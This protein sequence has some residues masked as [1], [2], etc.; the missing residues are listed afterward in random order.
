MASKKIH[1]VSL[2]CAKNQ[3]DSEMML[4][5]LRMAGW[6]ITEKPEAAQTIVV[7]TCSFIEAAIDE[8]IET[9]L[10]LAHY[11]KHGKCR[12]LIVTGCLPE[13]FRE[14]LGLE[15]P[16]VDYFLGT[17]GFDRIAAIATGESDAKRIQLPDPEQLEMPAEGLYR[18]RSDGPMA[19]LKIAEGCNRRCTYCVI[20]KLRGKQK[21]RSIEALVDE[22]K[23]LVAAGAKELVLIAQESSAYAGEG[24]KKGQLAQLLE[25]IA[26]SNADTWI[27]VLYLHPASIDDG[28]I[29]TMAALP[30]ICS[31][32]DIPIQ[33]ASDRMLKRMGRQ[34]TQ[35]DLYHLFERI[36]AK[37]PDATLRTTVMVGFPGET[38]ADFE[39]LLKFCDQIAFDH[40]GAFVY[41]DAEDIASHR[42]KGHID[43]KIAQN[44]HDR[45]MSGQQEISLAKLQHHVGKC[46][47]VLVEE[48][49]EPGLYLGRTR[50]Q[51]PEVDGVTYVHTKKAEI[52]DMLMTRITDALEYDIIG[53]AV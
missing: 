35:A 40:L 25:Q 32:F 9:I 34:Y 18:V 7:N 45:I 23:R 22:A 1:L 36:R 30:N 26:V 50:F 24:E 33:H 21:S 6:E 44:R 41:S 11:K 29:N 2:G 8:S 39:A 12:R 52:G 5:Q 20:P 10:S 49:V 47:P 42:L 15:L 48:T 38:E 37:M 27:R 31:Y 53:D 28:L 3:V 43:T 14:K 19:Y 13:R 46:Y 4:G 16:E 17:G 51:A